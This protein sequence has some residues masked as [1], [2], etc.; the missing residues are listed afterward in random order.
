MKEIRAEN[1][2]IAKD[3]ERILWFFLASASV[4]GVG[5]CYIWLWAWK[6]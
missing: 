2:R 5:I 3:A 6:A 1:D 4:W